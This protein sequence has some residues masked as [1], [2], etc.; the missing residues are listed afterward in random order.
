MIFR[1]PG[2]FFCGSP[3]CPLTPRG[4]VFCC[5]SPFHPPVHCSPLEFLPISVGM[6][7]L[8]V[9]RLVIVYVPAVSVYLP[10]LA[11]E[12]YSDRGTHRN[13]TQG[14]CAVEGVAFH[15]GCSGWWPGAAK[16]FVVQLPHRMKCFQLHQCGAVQHIL[17]RC[18][19]R[20][21]PIQ[22]PS[23]VLATPSSTLAFLRL[24]VHQGVQRGCG[25]RRGG[26]SQAYV[27]RGACVLVPELV[28]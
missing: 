10:F 28:A 14:M 20:L 19:A 3:A 7:G 26:E 18:P 12:P 22:E 2:I 21:H 16:F 6:A 8:A 24:A 25:C 17:L 13:L 23:D 4:G 1:S 5:G 15:P 11:D 27:L 9:R